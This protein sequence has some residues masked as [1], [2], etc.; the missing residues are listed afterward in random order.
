MEKIVSKEQFAGLRNN[1]IAGACPELINSSITFNGTDNILF[2][3]ENLKL[4]NTSIRFNGS[5][6]VVF[7]SNS[8]K[9]Y[10]LDVSINNNSVFYV[11]RDN[12]FNG[13]L[14]VVISEEKNVVV[15][16]NCLFS[17]GVWLRTADPHLIYSCETKERVNYSKSIFVG[18]HVWIGQDAMLLKNSY[19]GSGSIVAA[20]A[21]VAGK[22]I[23]SN[24]SWGGNPAR[25]LS[26][27]IFWD[28]SCVHT[29]TE[30]K[31][32]QYK[33]MDTDQYIFEEEKT[34]LLNMDDIDNVFSSAVGSEAKLE[35]AKKL[36]FNTDKNRFYLPNKQ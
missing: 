6:S 36:C 13:A 24:E 7:L 32:K 11:G 25:Q 34:Q 10:S 22:K 21:L 26:R 31:T 3:G 27:G 23:P 2:C 19:I 5:N 15:G 8:R 18:D 17:F 4:R 12:Y 20:K 9:E 35:E 29:W 28:G 30:E 14:H 33:K 1:R 16:D